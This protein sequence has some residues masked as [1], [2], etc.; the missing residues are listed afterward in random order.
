MRNLNRPLQKLAADR[1]GSAAV[2]FALVAPVYV[3]LVMGA[4][5][6]GYNFDSTTKMYTAIR[7]SGRLATLNNSSTKLQSGQTMNSKIIA[8]VKNALTAEGLPGSQMT[9]TITHANGNS[10]GTT[11]DLSDP[12]NDFQYFRIGVSVPYSAVNT[13]GFLPSSQSSLAASIVFRKGRSSLVN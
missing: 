9:V 4:I 6:S 2:E 13:G 10:A 7:Q 3:A 5:Q 8:D 12:N 1:R 11:F